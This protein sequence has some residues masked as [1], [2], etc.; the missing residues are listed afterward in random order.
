MRNFSRAS[1]KKKR[2][3]HLYSCAI[4]KLWCIFQECVIYPYLDDFENKETM[5]SYCYIYFN[6]YIIIDNTL[7]LNKRV[8]RPLISKKIFKMPYK[9]LIVFN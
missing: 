4:K 8:Q 7:K 6:E 3:F 5:R 1:K 9:M 2:N